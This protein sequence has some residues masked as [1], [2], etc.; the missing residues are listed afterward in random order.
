[1][2]NIYFT[3]YD[4][5]AGHRSTANALKEVIEQQKL[6]WKVEVVE[7][8]KEVFGTTRPQFVYNNWV[9]KKKWAKLINDPLS[10]PLFKLEIRLRHR[11]WRKRL[12]QYWREHKP[13]LVVS[14]M[15]LVNRVLYESV[16]AESPETPFV[17][18][19]TD[20]A[21]C[22]PNFWI[23][24]QEQLLICPSERAVKQA[25]Y[26]GYPDEKIFRTSGVVIHPRFNDAVTVDRHIE[27]QRLGLDPDLPTGLVIF[28]SHGSKE[29]IEIA[30]RLE[31]SSLNLQLIYICGRNEQLAK[32]LRSIPSRFPKYVEGFTKQIPY[33]MDLCD[34]FIG[35]PGS[36]G[37]S[38]AIA[39]KLPVIT[40][41]NNTTTLFQERASA[42]WL[43]ENGFGIVVENFRD[44]NKAVA[45]LIQPENFPRYRANVEAYNNRAVFEVV[46]ILEKILERSD[47]K[48]DQK[49]IQV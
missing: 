4:M 5:G 25:Q 16:L 19:M 2:K 23:E 14:L 39:R 12:Q 11:A 46:N 33:Y 1:M 37:V 35:K 36:V 34:F 45:E 15:P 28:G 48:A 43:A 47:L 38:E 30:E 31:Q 9:L 7:V 42:D 6:P 13:D 26:F 3:I 49:L 10:V 8:F 32:D 17:T 24:P 22:P 44:I 20:F 27:R 40:E 41:C 29:M 21:D 18:F